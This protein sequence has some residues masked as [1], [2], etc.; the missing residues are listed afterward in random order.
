MR[1]LHPGKDQKSTGVPLARR[2]IFTCVLS[3]FSD[4][5]KIYLLYTYAEP[6]TD[7]VLG[8]YVYTNRITILQEFSVKRR[9]K[10]AYKNSK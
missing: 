9:H 1:K 3:Y 4:S 5:V 6:D 7:K 10:P 2:I 8:I